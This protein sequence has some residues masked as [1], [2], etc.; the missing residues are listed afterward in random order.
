MATT[1]VSDISAKSNSRGIMRSMFDR[2]VEGRERQV[3]RYVE[4]NFHS[5]LQDDQNAVTRGT[6]FEGNTPTR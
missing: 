1:R 2:I 3:R 4:Q 5:L 6:F